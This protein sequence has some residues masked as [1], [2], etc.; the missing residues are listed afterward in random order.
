MRMIPRKD[1]SPGAEVPARE[2]EHLS[3]EVV[4]QLPIALNFRQ[5]LLELRTESG[6]L[7]AV[8]RHLTQ[9][10]EFLAKLTAARVKAGSNGHGE[11]HGASRN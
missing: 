4:A 8:I 9:L 6:R 3:Y 7:D 5:T 11:G 1:L 2:A 10:K